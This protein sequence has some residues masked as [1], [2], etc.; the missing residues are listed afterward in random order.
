MGKPGTGV[1]GELEQ[2][3]ESRR[4]DTRSRTLFGIAVQLFLLLLPLLPCH[5]LK[6]L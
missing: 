5:R 2:S 3:R 6:R 4:D 1:P